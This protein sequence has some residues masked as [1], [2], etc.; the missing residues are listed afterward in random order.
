MH[1]AG[2]DAA[3]SQLVQLLVLLALTSCVTA[4][5]ELVSTDGFLSA[6]WFR[7]TVSGCLLVTSVLWFWICTKLC[8]GGATPED[9]SALAMDD[10]GDDV[11]NDEDDDD[12]KH[13]AMLAYYQLLALVESSVQRFFLNTGRSIAKWP[14]TWATVSM[15]ICLGC[16]TL[17]ALTIL[18]QGGG[19]V[20][21][22]FAVLWAPAESNVKTAQRAV[23]DENLF[24]RG[25]V[26]PRIK[27]SMIFTSADGGNVLTEEHL[28]AL[29]EIQEDLETRS[30]YRG[31]PTEPACFVVKTT[32]CYRYSP[33]DFWMPGYMD[34]DP[35]YEG[36]SDAE[37]FE[38]SFRYEQV[39]GPSLLNVNFR[40][41]VLSSP[42]RSWQCSDASCG[43]WSD[44]TFAGSRSAWRRHGNTT[45]AFRLTYWRNDAKEVEQPEWDEAFLGFRP[46]ED[47]PLKLEASDHQVFFSREA[48]RTLNE[49][50]PSVIVV[51]T[52]AMILYVTGV[53]IS[54]SCAKSRVCLGFAGLVGTITSV[55]AG[56]SLMLFF[57]LKISITSVLVPVVV[58]SIGVD[59]MFVLVAGLDHSS[60]TDTINEHIAQTMRATGF[61]IS[62]TTLTDALAFGVGTFSVLPA[63]STMSKMAVAC[64][65]LDFFMQVCW[66]V[67]WMVL[68]AHRRSKGRMDCMMCF[69]CCVCGGSAGEELLP[70]EGPKAD[71]HAA[72]GFL[73]EK[74]APVIVSPEVSGCILIVTPLLALLGLF[75]VINLNVGVRYES[76]VPFDSHV[77]TYAL[78]ERKFF[79]EGVSVPLDFVYSNTWHASD[80]KEFIR[81]TPTAEDQKQLDDFHTRVSDVILPS[82]LVSWWDS[83][84]DSNSTSGPGFIQWFRD[85]EGEEFVDPE[86]WESFFSTWQGTPSPVGALN[87]DVYGLDLKDG[88]DSGTGSRIFGVS[89]P[90]GAY[91]WRTPIYLGAV[92]RRAAD[93]G[94][95]A[96]SPDL[97]IFEGSTGVF[98]S[99]VFDVFCTL[100]ILFLVTVL[101]LQEPGV[102]GLLVLCMFS[103]IFQV[104]G[105]FAIL[106]V[107]M[108]SMTEV[109]LII[110]L[111]LGVDY[112]SHIASGYSSAPGDR[113]A[114]ATAAIAIHGPSVVHGFTTTALGVAALLVFAH[115]A[116][117]VEFG[118]VLLV[119]QFIGIVHA[120]VV[121]P[122]LLASRGSL[123]F[124]NPVIAVLLQAGNEAAPGHT[125]M[126]IDLT[127]VKRGTLANVRFMQTRV[128]HRNAVAKSR[129]FSNEFLKKAGVKARYTLAAVMDVTDGDA[130]EGDYRYS[131]MAGGQGGAGRASQR[132]SR[133]SNSRSQ[134]SKLGM[135]RPVSQFTSADSVGSRTRPRKGSKNSRNRSR[136]GSKTSKGSKGSRGSGSGS[137]SRER[138]KKSPGRRTENARNPGR[139]N[140]PG[141]RA[142]KSGSPEKRGQSPGRGISPGRGNGSPGRGASPGRGNGSPGRGRSPSPI[143]IAA[144]GSMKRKS[145]SPAKLGGRGS[146][147][148]GKRL[149]GARSSMGSKNAGLGQYASKKK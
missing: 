89:L 81:N 42:I 25:A 94:F 23:E 4:Q 6:T 50:P 99:L 106:D 45:E 114:K 121:L 74:F 146:M 98:Q 15:M 136:K 142:G 73:G 132:L 55:G 77:A 26:Q 93:F 145:Q 57:G 62:M 68:D 80:S 95:S 64:V 36:K 92:L 143:K 149:S 103:M 116:V 83:R 53:F 54:K 75:S 8:V 97:L 1:H 137:A 14:R 100:F 131:S 76:M 102:S 110:A 139:S 16:I 39:A 123:G 133:M 107:P 141:R 105:I 34:P 69:M 109:G 18:E 11:V 33:L 119:V 66:F 56:M 108:N 65:L 129:M 148:A 9:Y 120:F 90:M 13:P 51:P 28:N 52:I 32:N 88:V 2:S 113:R 5:D 22:D 72:S 82:T 10:K 40:N 63:V 112:L 37:L 87:G 60:P 122:A 31:S 58:L 48:N 17:G 85:T 147:N 38:D 124:R 127:K 140:S 43:G 59:D 29:W 24:A 96:F 7:V 118:T 3:R 79:G 41:D 104:L 144:R 115:A 135:Y 67:P 111:G 19:V 130:G 128:A 47:S 126:D 134:A 86:D 70:E 101:F 12:L 30:G 71:H 44:D 21:N 49:L 117:L 78:A 91:R 138:R 84:G 125:S 61:A 46:E 35:S 27:A 20:E